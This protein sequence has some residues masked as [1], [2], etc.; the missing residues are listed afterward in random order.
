MSIIEHAAA[1][2]LKA[3]EGQTRKESDVPYIVH[4]MAVALILARYGFPE[5]VQAAALV[6]DVVEDTPVT[7]DDIREELGG[8]IADL[9]APVTHDDSLGWTEKKKAYIETLR[10]ASEDAKAIATADKIANARSLLTGYDEQGLTIWS[11]FNAGRDKKIWFEKSMLAMLQESW[12]HPLVD[13][14]ATLV[15]RM[16][17]LPFE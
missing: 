12:E 16:E 1:L 13:E 3:H 6:H 15:D 4:P 9:V 7:L 8:Q 2:A 11:Y 10:S 14:Y 5:T 17:A